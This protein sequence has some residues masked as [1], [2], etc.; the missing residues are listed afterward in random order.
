MNYLA[1]DADD[2]LREITQRNVEYRPVESVKQPKLKR[3]ALVATG[4]L[5]ALSMTVCSIAIHLKKG[6][7]MPN[8][9]SS[10]IQGSN[11]RS[12]TSF[13][14]VLFAGAILIA[15]LAFFYA[16]RD[17]TAVA[18]ERPASKEFLHAG[19]PG[20]EQYRRLINVEGLEATQTSRAPG[21]IV[22]ELTATVSNSTGQTIKELEMRGVVFNE[23]R[24]PVGA[25]TVSVIPKQQAS[26]EPN[27]TMKAHILIE[28]V[29]RR[30]HRKGIDMEVTGVRFE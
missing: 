13:A 18:P 27:E 7:F 24:E 29:P 12:N 8:H 19:L 11:L 28:G 22:M 20:F 10:S 25:R 17:R 1:G 26:L 4:T 3:G 23:R 5:V 15:L 30:A 21:V 6:G 2:E 16:Q 9:N 14:S